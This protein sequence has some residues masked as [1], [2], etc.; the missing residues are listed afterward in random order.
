MNISADEQHKN[1]V[2]DNDKWLFQLRCRRDRI[3]KL[4]RKN[5]SYDVKTL[6]EAEGHYVD[7]MIHYRE[8]HV[9]IKLQE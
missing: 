9:E 5:D 7:A 4:I 8:H 1:K 3:K 2:R 6:L